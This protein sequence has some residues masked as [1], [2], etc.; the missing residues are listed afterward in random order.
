MSSIARDSTV[1]APTMSGAKPCLTIGS[2]RSLDGDQISLLP[3]T[4]RSNRKYPAPGWVIVHQPN[5]GIEVD[6]FLRLDLLKMLAEDVQR[7]IGSLAGS[8]Y[9]QQ[10]RTNLD[11][12]L[13]GM[14]PND[15]PYGASFLPELSPPS[16]RAPRSS[17]QLHQL[18]SILQ[19][20]GWKS[21]ERGSLL[22]CP[23]ENAAFG[24]EYWLV[25][26]NTEFNRR[27]RYP[28][29]FVVQLWP[30]QET[31]SS[32]EKWKR[33][34]RLVLPPLDGSTDSL[35][36][37]EETL[38]CFD[39]SQ[40]WLEPCERCFSLD[41]KRP[42]KLLVRNNRSSSCLRCDGGTTSWPTEICTISSKEMELIRGRL[43]AHLK[44]STN[45]DGDK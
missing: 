9:A 33:D 32:P 28:H 37:F 12:V 1:L 13:S 43:L 29:I 16:H 42:F 26:S 17:N 41:D 38:F 39:V 45:I 2:Y 44:L 8:S 30:A 24:G 14:S 36:A 4:S 23:E 7:E 11:T 5:G 19:R 3:L 25:V 40:Q 31:G 20:A 6:S 34:G 21:P 10:I 27:F 22:R 18:Y 15:D 35:V